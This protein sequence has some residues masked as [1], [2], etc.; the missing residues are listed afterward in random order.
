ML[1]K[2]LV[3]AA[4]DMISFVQKQKKAEK[5]DLSFIQGLAPSF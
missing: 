2:Q 3:A 1:Q 4:V 5:L